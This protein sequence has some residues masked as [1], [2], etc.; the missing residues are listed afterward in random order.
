M[1]VSGIDGRAIVL[2]VRGPMDAEHGVV[3][4][5]DMVGGEVRDLPGG[6]ADDEVSALSGQS[7]SR[8]IGQLATH[9]IEHDIDAVSFGDLYQT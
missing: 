4:H 1:T 7:A 9:R 5:Q 2:G 3:L 6:E 8:C